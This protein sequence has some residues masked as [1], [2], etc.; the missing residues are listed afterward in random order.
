MNPGR[1]LV[2]KYPPLL[3]VCSAFFVGVAVGG[4]TVPPANAAAH[5]APHASPQTDQINFQQLASNPQ[6][7]N[8]VNAVM[9]SRVYKSQGF[10]YAVDATLRSRSASRAQKPGNFEYQLRNA[11]TRCRVD[12]ERIRC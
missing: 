4:N 10:R 5:V 1:V 11:I 6:F 7:A 12:G 8:A 2:M 9:E 3:L